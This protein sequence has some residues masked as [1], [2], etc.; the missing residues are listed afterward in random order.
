MS[1]FTDMSRRGFFSSRRATNNQ[2]LGPCGTK[3]PNSEGLQPIEKPP[4]HDG[5]NL[6]ELPPLREAML[7][8]DEIASLFDDIQNQGTDI[9]LMQRPSSQTTRSNLDTNSTLAAAKIAF[10]RGDIK[11]LQIRYRWRELLWIDTLEQQGQAARLVR[12]SHPLS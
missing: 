11:R 8:R 10:L 9:T 12:V 7:S 1:K 2:S 3:S 4:N 5:M 6:D